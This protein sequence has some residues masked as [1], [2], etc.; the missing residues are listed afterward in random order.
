MASEQL[1]FTLCFR[2]LADLAAPDIQAD[3]PDTLFQI[4]PK[5]EPWIEAWTALLNSNEPD[6]QV[7]QAKMRLANPAFIP[8]NHLVEEAI[9]A[10]QDDS[11]FEPFHALVDVL[12]DPYRYRT[13]SE[14]YAVPPT[15]DQTVRQTFCGT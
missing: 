8:R 6:Q 7:R 3:I 10:A 13:E 4:P 5:L 2:K 1:D 9:D 11:D 12:A 15:P 14:R